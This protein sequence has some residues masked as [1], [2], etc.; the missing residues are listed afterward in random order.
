MPRSSVGQPEQGSPGHASARTSRP[1]ARWA[2]HSGGLLFGPIFIKQVRDDVTEGTSALF[3]LT[4]DEVPDKMAE[5]TR[6]RDLKFKIV[7]NNLTREQEDTLQE[8]FRAA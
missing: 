8:I 6:A 4:A 3:L 2:A 1:P 5:E 7:A